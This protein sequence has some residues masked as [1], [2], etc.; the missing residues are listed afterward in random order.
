MLSCS[1]VD[2][3]TTLLHPVT[4]SAMRLH[5]EAVDAKQP[6]VSGPRLLMHVLAAL[7]ATSLCHANPKAAYMGFACNLQ[8][9][10]VF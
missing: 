5:H 4:A 2:A 1:A 8:H 10:E 6:R 9:F 7:A 3:S